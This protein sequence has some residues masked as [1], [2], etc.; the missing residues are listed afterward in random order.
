MYNFVGW[1][2]YIFIMCVVIVNLDV[3]LWKKGVMTGL[4]V[5]EGQKV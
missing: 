3:L 2:G 5:G 1:M 4:S